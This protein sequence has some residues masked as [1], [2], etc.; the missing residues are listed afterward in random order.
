MRK[1]A[2]LIL[3]IFN[4]ICP[5]CQTKQTSGQGSEHFVPSDVK[6]G[7]DFKCTNEGCGQFFRLPTTL[8]ATAEGE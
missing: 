5:H 8:R 3:R 4:I 6:P 7:Q 1:T 2:Q